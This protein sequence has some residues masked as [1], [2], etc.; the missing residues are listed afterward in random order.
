MNQKVNIADQ[1]IAFHPDRELHLN[2]FLDGFGHHLASWRHPKSDLNQ[3]A[4]QR[5]LNSALIAEQGKFDAVFLADSLAMDPSVVSNGKAR[6]HEVEPLTVL[7]AIAA[8]TTH[9]GLIGTA[10]TTYNEPYH[11]ARKFASLDVISNGRTGWNLVT[12]DLA[13]EA[14]NF[15]ID[16][17]VKHADRYDR[18]EEF[19]DVV[20]GLWQTWN[21]DVILKDKAQGQYFDPAKINVLNHTGRH[22]SVKGPLNVGPSLQKHPIIVQA[23]SS[24]RGKELAARTANVIFTAQSSLESA[25]QFYADVKSRLSKYGRHANDLNVLPGLYVVVAKTKEEALAKQ[26][27]LDDLIDESVGLGLLGRMLG[28]FDLSGIDVNGLLP[29]LDQTQTGQQSRQELFTKLSHEQG[30][31][32]KQLYGRVASGRGHFSVVGTAEEVADHI[33]TWFKQGA[34]DGFNIMPGLLPDG[35]QDFVELVVPLLQRR[36]LFRTE[37]QEN[38]LRA[39]YQPTTSFA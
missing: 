32:V 26:K 6:G 22:F 3:S 23:G 28:N 31:T 24:D 29:E 8:Q 35:A 12:T 11:I 18:A 37:Y 7:S 14:Q 21:D 33:E 27:T 9:I 2:L 5:F 15:N 1:S 34:A 16:E 36:G 38:T 10:T 17:H 19:Y 4:Y 39:R 30:Y 20:T 25:Q 13:A